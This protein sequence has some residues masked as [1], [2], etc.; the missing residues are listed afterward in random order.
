MS[1]HS[2]E[3][4]RLDICGE[5]GGV[6]FN[7]GDFPKVAQSQEAL[8]DVIAHEPQGLGTSTAGDE[9]CPVHCVRLCP[10][11]YTGSQD[12]HIAICPSCHGTFIDSASILRLQAVSERR[13][14]VDPVAPKYRT[15]PMIDPGHVYTDIDT[16]SS[17]LGP[18]R[19]HIFGVKP[20][21][22][23]SSTQGREIYI[24]AVWEALGELRR[25][26]L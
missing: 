6:W 10:Y 8:Q 25:G 26:G 3:S 22:M 18:P 15:L 16:G 4:I 11:N 13:E 21:P 24:G 14:Q 17:F 19:T 9:I 2:V 5:C 1:E 7:P 20:A 12:V 23:I